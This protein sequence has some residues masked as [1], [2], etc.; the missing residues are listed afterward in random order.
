[1]II[2]RN[3]QRI[4]TSFFGSFRKMDVSELLNFKP[5]SA[6]KRP[7]ASTG[8]EEIGNDEDFDDDPNESYEK[9]AAKRQKIK[10]AAQ[11]KLEEVI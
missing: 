1:M 4:I 11:K 6:P 10:K 8:N 3:I 7:A 2:V 9:R 5:T